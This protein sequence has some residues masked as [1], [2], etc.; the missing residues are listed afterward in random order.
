MF[1]EQPSMRRRFKLTWPLVIVACAGVGI[2]LSFGLCGASLING[3][4]A[5]V[6]IAVSSI[7]TAGVVLFWLSI[8]CLVVGFAWM[9]IA[10]VV[11]RVRK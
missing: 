10:A 5:A 11:N 8:L 7:A 1:D 4:R 2:L 6:G 3:E 9:F